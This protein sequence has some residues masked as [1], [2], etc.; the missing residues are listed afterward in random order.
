MYK[1]LSRLRPLSVCCQT[2]TLGSISAP[3][4]TDPRPRKIITRIHDKG[5]RPE[6][7]HHF[8]SSCCSITHPLHP[9]CVSPAARRPRQSYIVNS[10]TNFFF[11]EVCVKEEF[12]CPIQVLIVAVCAVYRKRSLN[13]S[14]GFPP[15]QV[16]SKRKDC[17]TKPF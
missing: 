9:P 13:R 10:T 11:E 17:I 2:P 6:A 8:A 3:K 7:Y 5:K 16:A 4:T 14:A 15:S 1:S 12:G